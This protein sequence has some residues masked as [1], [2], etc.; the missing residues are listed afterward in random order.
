MPRTLTLISVVALS[1]FAFA[2]SKN[3]AAISGSS[4]PSTAVPT[5]ITTPWFTG[6]RAARVPQLAIGSVQLKPTSKA[7]LMSQNLSSA[8]C[9]TMR[10]YK[11]KRTE[12]LSDGDTGVRGYTTCEIFSNFQVR[13]AVGVQMLHVDP[14]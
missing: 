4:L 11:V 12:R 8:T 1:T 3:V 10:M 14:Q 5:T 2:G 9:G 13:S 6:M 7:R